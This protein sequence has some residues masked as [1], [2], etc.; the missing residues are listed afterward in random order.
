MLVMA[1]H[2]PV[3]IPFTHPGCP[4]KQG[5]EKARVRGKYVSVELVKE[6]PDGSVEW[7][8]ATSSDAGG[9]I[10]RFITNASMPKNVAEDVPSF[11][12]WM[13]KRFP[14]E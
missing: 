4:E 7:R 5:E 11:L 14:V 10:P 12:H 6:H 2:S 13:W 9:N 1:N 3:S 8:M